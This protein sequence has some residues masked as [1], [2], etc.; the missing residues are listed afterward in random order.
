MAIF[1]FRRFVFRF[2]DE[3][4]LPDLGYARAVVARSQEVKRFRADGRCTATE[5][6][7]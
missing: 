1:L 4:S 2:A 3:T 6:I 7:F 5:T